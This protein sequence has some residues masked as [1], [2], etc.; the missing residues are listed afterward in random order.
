MLVSKNRRM[1]LAPSGKWLSHSSVL[2]GP[3]LSYAYV[4]DKF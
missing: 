3:S 4:K 1:F 2:Q